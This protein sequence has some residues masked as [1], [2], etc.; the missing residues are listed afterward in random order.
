MGYLVIAGVGEETPHPPDLTV[1]GMDTIT[2]A[3]LYLTLRNDVSDDHSPVYRLG[4]DVDEITRAG[5]CVCRAAF[6][7]QG[8]AQEA[9]AVGAFD[10][11]AFLGAVQL[12]EFRAR[13]AQPE[14]ATRSV[15]Q[16]QGN[17][18][19]GLPP[20]PRLD[21]KVGDR[22]RCRVDD[23]TPHFAAY[24]IRAARRGP[25][26]E[27]CLLCHCRPPFPV[28]VGYRY[29]LSSVILPG[30]SP[31]ERDGSRP[32][33]PKATCDA[34]L[35]PPRSGFN[36]HLP[37]NPAV[38]RQCRQGGATMTEPQPRNDFASF[39]APAEGILVA[40]FITVREVARSR[41]FYSRILGGTVI[42]E[43]NP[44]TVRLSNSWII[45]N[46]GGPPTPD[47]PGISV[48]DYQPGDT[49]SIFLNLRVADIHACYEQWKS[50]GAEFVTPPI[51]RGAEIR[52]YMRDPDGYL[53]EVGQSTGLLHGHLAAKRPEDLPG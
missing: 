4:A 13:A 43:E 46:P 40:M 8:V 44:C 38:V 23:H 10:H 15:D 42:L 18:P 3:H 34:A 30:A 41:D 12:A 45:M 39:P 2:W 16:V 14:F 48:V 6:V 35:S 5:R 1:D 36:W 24:T 52:C 20:V 29:L 17:E 26:R 51:D 49:T 9:T 27:L 32:L 19:P 31:A 33:R 7:Y 53:I 11:V 37:G 22:V 28:I 25:D 50:K 47:K 21:D